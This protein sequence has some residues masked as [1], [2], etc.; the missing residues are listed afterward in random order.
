VRPTIYLIA[1]H[2]YGK[3]LLRK[4]IKFGVMLDQLALKLN[5]LD[6]L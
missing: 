3:L 4:M 2:S 1:K 5:L 6:N